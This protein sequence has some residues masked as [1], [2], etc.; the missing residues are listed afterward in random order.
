M[1][2]YIA[3]LRGINVSGKNKILM[4]D[5]K[6]M[7]QEM[8]FKDV[9][10]YIQSGNVVLKTLE[11]DSSQIELKIRDKIY[12]TF[13]FTIPVIVLDKNSFKKIWEENP[14]D[15]VPEEAKK[16]IYFTLFQSSPEISLLKSFKKEFFPNEQFGVN[17]KCCYLNCLKGYGKAKLNNNLL[18]RKLKIVATTRNYKT[19]KT[20]MSLV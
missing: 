5:L 12:T 17:E 20:L 10:T 14:F 13:S 19:M 8:G 18:E 16:N 2:T 9:Q 6:I 4:A 1:K 11:K 7:L 3:L 15:I